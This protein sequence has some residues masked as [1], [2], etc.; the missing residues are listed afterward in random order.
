MSAQRDERFGDFLSRQPERLVI[1]GFRCCMAGY[2]FLDVAC[3]ETGW[4]CYIGEVGPEQARALMGEAQSGV[5]TIRYSSQKSVS[6]YPQGCR[7]LCHDECMALSAISAA[8]GSDAVAGRM[9][10]RHLIGSNDGGSIDG[11]W[12]ATQGFA[13]ALV[14]SGQ[15]LYPVTAAVVQSIGNMQALATVPAKD[16]N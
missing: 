16:M 10:T 8:Q 3:W 14:H 6:Y 1:T 7:Q 11:V 5:R 4:Q 15:P 2:D 9:A 12:T 13:Q